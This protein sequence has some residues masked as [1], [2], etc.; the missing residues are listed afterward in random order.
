M[1]CTD[2]GVRA[3]GQP[4]VSGGAEEEVIRLFLNGVKEKEEEHKGRTN[5]SR[6]EGRYALTSMFVIK[7]TI[8]D[9]K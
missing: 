7:T 5:S 1:E 9:L 6:Y 4:A 8:S 3:C 2:D